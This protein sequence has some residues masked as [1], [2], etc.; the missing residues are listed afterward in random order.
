MRGLANSR[1]PDIPLHRE[2][3]TDA[4]PCCQ[5]GGS[6]CIEGGENN[7]FFRGWYVLLLTSGREVSGRRP[8]HQLP[9]TG[10]QTYYFISIMF[11]PFGVWFCHGMDTWLLWIR[12]P[13]DWQ[14]LVTKEVY[15]TDTALYHGGAF[16]SETG[17]GGGVAQYLAFHANSVL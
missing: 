13:L 7:N 17:V 6:L 3:A 12:Y 4:A 2:T 14:L 15:H 10:R 8:P 9:P 1:S 11:G 16:T 5:S